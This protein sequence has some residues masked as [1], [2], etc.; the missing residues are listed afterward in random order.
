MRN[1]V[2]CDWVE[3]AKRRAAV[4][5]VKNIKDNFIVGLG[6]GSTAAYA[7]EEI[8]RMIREKGLRILGVPS[9]Y[10]SLIMAAKFKVPTTTLYEHPLIDLTID[11]ADQIDRNLNLI[12]GGGG[13]LTRE[14]VIAASSRCLIIVAD[15][16]KLTD[17]L[18][19]G[20][21]L[22]VEILPFAEPLVTAKIREMGGK[23]YLRESKKGVPFITDNGNFILDVDFGVIENPLELERRLKM[24]PGVVETGL[25]VGMV[26]AAYI[27]TRTAV[28]KIS[29]SGE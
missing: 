8:G 21:L 4:E 29:V 17:N 18:G 27:G 1:N 20:Q 25:F 12:K 19:R 11:G 22:P 26:K 28:K 15:E 7:I 3:E 24:I 16:R 5:A 6:S 2:G 9:S 13:A 10:Q 14:K 23:P